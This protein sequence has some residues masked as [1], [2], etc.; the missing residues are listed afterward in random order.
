MELAAGLL[1]GST[2]TSQQLP[3]RAALMRK[4]LPPRIE[5]SDHVV[6]AITLSA[7]VKKGMEG[8]MQESI[9]HLQHEP[10]LNMDYVICQV[11]P[12]CCSILI[13]S[14]LKPS[15]CPDSW[16]WHYCSLEY[17]CRAHLSREALPADC[18]AHWGEGLTGS[19][20]LDT[21]PKDYSGIN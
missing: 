18:D 2:L 13:C 3:P 12:N 7:L 17:A 6:G 21:L 1:L 5:A 14:G 20:W 11:M 19:L 10:N 8:Q 4:Y 9:L 15:R 16:Q